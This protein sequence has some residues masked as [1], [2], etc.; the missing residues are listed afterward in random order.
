MVWYKH[1]PMA[2]TIAR[3]WEFISSLHMLVKETGVKVHQRRFQNFN[4][5]AGNA[6]ND[7]IDRNYTTLRIIK[8][9][10]NKYAFINQ[11]ISLISL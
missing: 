11:A 9:F 2:L 3:G 1:Q 5:R 4:T 8:S 7:I 10:K 6:F